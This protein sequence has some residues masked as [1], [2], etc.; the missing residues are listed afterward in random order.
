MTSLGDVVDANAPDQGSK[1]NESKGWE[2]P[3]RT[4]TRTRAGRSVQPS[5]PAGLLGLQGSARVAPRSVRKPDSTGLVG[6]AT[7][8]QPSAWA[9]ARVT[10]LDAVKRQGKVL[11][12]VSGLRGE[13]S[14]RRNDS[15]GKKKKKKKKKKKSGR[16]LIL[17]P[18]GSRWWQDPGYAASMARLGGRTC[19]ALF[20]EDME[21]RLKCTRPRNS[22]PVGWTDRQV[23]IFGPLRPAPRNEEGWWACR[24]LSLS[25]NGGFLGFCHGRDR[26]R[27]YEG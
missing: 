27:Q 3:T 23:A 13:A 2:A 11:R 14:I 26:V 1:K 25:P 9:E 15:C 6:K 20:Y 17:K 18:H 19:S 16:R 4:R 22:P 12:H 5:L 7:W 21:T 8:W 24:P 10:S